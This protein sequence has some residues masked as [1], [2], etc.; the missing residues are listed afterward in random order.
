[1]YDYYNNRSKFELGEY[2]D[3]FGRTCGYYVP[4]V[5]SIGDWGEL[6]IVYHTDD[7]K[8]FRACEHRVFVKFQR[9]HGRAYAKNRP[10]VRRFVALDK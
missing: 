10:E 9:D 1:M 4:G 2:R 5:Y 7:E 8:Q 6:H 3:Q